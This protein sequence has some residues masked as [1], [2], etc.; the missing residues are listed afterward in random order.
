[1]VPEV[2]AD[3]EEPGW[4]TGER[5]VSSFS[6]CCNKEAYVSQSAEEEEGGVGESDDGEMMRNV[7]TRETRG[8]KAA[9][10]KLNAV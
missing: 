6:F 8:P 7:R 1:M 5:R 2:A 10:S 9:R 4:G 3:G